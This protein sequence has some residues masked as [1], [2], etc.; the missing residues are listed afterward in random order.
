MLY[1]S[2]FVGKTAYGVVDTDDG[3][4]DIVGVSVLMEAL[5]T[6]GNIIVG[7]N[8]VPTGGPLWHF[9][10]KIRPYQPSETMTQLQ[11][12]TSLLK[13]ID[14]LTYNSMVTSVQVRAS[15]ITAPVTIRLSDF[16]SMCADGVFRGLTWEGRHTV[17]VVIDDRIKFL[18][19]SFDLPVEDKARCL[20][21]DGAGIMFDLREVSRPD[22]YKAVYS[23]V[24]DRNEIEVDRTIVDVPER[25]ARMMKAMNSW[26]KVF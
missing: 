18:E 19:N 2:R 24:W 7:A 20:G 10:E 26:V 8:A 16:G 23:A 1:V 5:R 6:V 4:E 15:E 12:K 17:T 22:V 9:I 14:V 3:V 11:V 25:K 21:V 13:H